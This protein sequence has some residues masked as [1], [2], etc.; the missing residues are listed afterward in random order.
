MDLA[1][2]AVP[3]GMRP[4]GLPSG[5]QLVGPRGSD[6][7]LAA[8]AR[9]YHQRVGGSMGATGHPLPASAGP[10]AGPAS[11][12][13]AS[14]AAS[15]HAVVVVGAHLRGQ[16]LNRQLVELGASFVRAGATAPKYRLYALRGTVPPKPGLVRVREG[17]S[18]I[19]V[20]VWSL[21]TTAFGAFVS[22]IPRPLCIGSIELDD[23]AFAQ[24]FLCESDVI[25]G[26]VD[27]SHH[28]G[29]RAFLDATARLP[30]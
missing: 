30:G 6:G 9:K 19:E 13:P 27:I 14:P 2:I 3:S 7:A 22:A 24:G 15:R 26:A 1:A 25:A 18:A 12:V 11:G 10:R 17:G 23:G 5:I 20:E 4:D 29:W 28:G 16:P 8:V 21:D